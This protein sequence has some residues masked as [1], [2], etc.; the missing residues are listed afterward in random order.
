VGGDLRGALATVVRHVNWLDQ[1]R[2]K[3]LIDRDY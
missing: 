1:Q 2:F 3:R